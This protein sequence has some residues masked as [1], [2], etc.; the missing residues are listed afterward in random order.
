M[1]KLPVPQPDRESIVKHRRQFYWNILFPVIL[2]SLLGLAAAILIGLA[3]FQN[4][5]DVARWAAISTIWL[6]IPAMLGNLI[7]LAL[8]GGSVYGLARLLKV[9]PHYTG[10]VQEYA[11]YFNAK[12]VQWTD[13]IVEPV[14][15]IKAW[16]ELLIGFLSR[17]K[18]EDSHAKQK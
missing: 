3:T 12:I 10:L 4:G 6:S 2:A 1:Q 5:G 16:I 7:L 18:E 8:V 11:L 15:K 17:E 13:S 14:L 9:T